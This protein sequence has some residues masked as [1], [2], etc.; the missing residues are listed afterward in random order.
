M[1][2]NST[3]AGSLRRRAW[4]W[5]FLAALLVVPFV[6]WQSVT[7]TMY[8]WSYAWVDANHPDLRFVK[9]SVQHASLDAQ[10]QTAR[11]ARP[12]SRVASLL[13]PS[14][15]RRS[16][17]VMFENAR[18]LP[19]A[20]F[21]DPYS[22]QL[23]GRLDA[24]GWLPGWSRKLH[25]GWPAG[26]VGSWLLELGA[27]W[28]IVMVLTGLVLWWPRD[29]RS[30][31]A[32][33][34]PRL[35]LGPRLFWRDLHACVAVWFSLVI[36][37]FLLTA[38]PWTSFWGDALLKPLQRS[39]GQQS[40][41]AAGFA[42]VMSTHSHQGMASRLASLDAMVR[43]ARA[44]GMVGDLLLNVAEGKPDAAVSLRNQRPRASDE[45]YALYDRHDG[46]RVGAADWRDFPPMAKAVATGV[47]IH[48]G[49]YFGSA[50]P[51]LNTVFALSL[52]WLSI[53]GLLAWWRRKPADALGVPA[54]PASPWPRWLK[55]CAIA[56]G[57][58]L[59]LLA[60]SAVIIWLAERGW[61]RIAKAAA[62]AP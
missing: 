20:V 33:L 28:T 51:W 41:A 52:V 26:K 14:D 54:R 29:G 32:A 59:P 39:L 40:P 5:H 42:P 46:K 38:L 1:V 8:L 27:C 60:L 24:P 36:V 7:G 31:I 18:G 48:E 47:D 21:V 50:G 25:G 11:D 12:G 3:P 53:T 44:Q 35:R 16:T 23:L 61:L 30:L 58:L 6:L 22:G 62:P 43:D 9:P 10:L 19:V 15:P 57:T 45:K 2:S 55:I 17:Q 49:S 4:R 13:L 37:L 34:I 56:V